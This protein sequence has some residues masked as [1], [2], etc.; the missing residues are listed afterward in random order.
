V[1][2][3]LNPLTGVDGDLLRALA[4]GDYLIN[5]FRNR[6]LRATMFG[7]CNEKT[8]CRRQAAKITRSLALLR[9]HGLIVKV[10]KT[11]RYQLSAFGRRVTTT[12]LAAHTANVAELTKA[13]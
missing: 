3:A 9:A 12:L 8:E 2:R 6:D 5:G 10:Q 1:A 11:H 4:Q 13:A 7:P